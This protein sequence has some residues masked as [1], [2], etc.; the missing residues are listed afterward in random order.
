MLAEGGDLGGR[1]CDAVNIQG[2]SGQFQPAT[3]VR[4]RS[5]VT[6]QE[7]LL[8]ATSLIGDLLFPLLK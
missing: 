2:K 7:I 1:A 8:V 6:V 3:G 4:T 5:N